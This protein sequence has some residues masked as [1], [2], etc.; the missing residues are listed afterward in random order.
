VLKPE[1]ASTLA[2]Y[3]EHVAEFQTATRA[4]EDAGSL[5]ID[6]KQGTIPHPAVAVRRNAGSRVQALAKEFGLTPSSEQDLAGDDGGTNGG[7]GNPF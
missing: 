5:F 2:A 3:C 1:D 6:A 4:L 7:D